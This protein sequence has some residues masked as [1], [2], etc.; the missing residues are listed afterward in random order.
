M[1]FLRFLEGKKISKKNNFPPL[2]HDPPPPHFT[3]LQW[4]QWSV[5]IIGWMSGWLSRGGNMCFVAHS[6]QSRVLPLWGDIWFFWWIM[7]THL[8]CNSYITAIFLAFTCP[9][10]VPRSGK[11][12]FWGVLDQS[13]AQLLTSLELDMLVV[14]C[15]FLM[16]YGDP[17]A[18]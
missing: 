17:F 11:M 4:P 15:D 18:W 10:W 8:H 6:S 3:H 5:V 2:V 7:V 13:I 9:Y 16:N 14:R 1:W 12:L